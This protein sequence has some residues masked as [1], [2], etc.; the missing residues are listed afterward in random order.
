MKIISIA[1][2]KGGVGKT[3]SAVNLAAALAELGKKVLCIDFDPQ[4]N[5]SDYLDY[6]GSD[7]PTI[8]HLMYDVVNDVEI[9]P[10]SSICHS[11]FEN[12]DYIPSTIALSSAECFLVS[13]VARETVLKR[14]L[15]NDEL[16]ESGYDYVIIDCLPSLGVLLVNA[17][18]ASDS[19]II[20]VQAQKFSLD[21]LQMFLATF[22]Q[23]Q[24]NINPNLKID[25]ILLTMRDN[26]NMS[27]AVELS[28]RSEYEDVVFE[29]SIGKSVE[30]TNSTY[31]HKPLVF[32]KTSKLG[33]E[34]MS[35]AEEM[36]LKE[37]E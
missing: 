22:R 11:S 4:G 25:G 7:A 13:A 12:L 36:I 8:S 30:A 19:V 32:H 35:L 18:A 2:Q 17:L 24:K 14:I 15:Q 31:E 27:G 10:V 16:L 33:K 9:N 1:N 37:G 5:L 23:I 26:T 20:P 29:Q 28:L 34:Y 21:G 3:T 6:K